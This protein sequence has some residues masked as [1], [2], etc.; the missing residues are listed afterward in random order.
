MAENAR[1]TSDSVI[2]V[3]WVLWR[4]GSD[5]VADDAF[6]A[7]KGRGVVVVLLQV[8]MK[9]NSW[10]VSERKALLLEVTKRKNSPKLF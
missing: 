3:G 7:E 6:V 9:R 10:K 4:Y 2:F 8:M 1:V 5:A